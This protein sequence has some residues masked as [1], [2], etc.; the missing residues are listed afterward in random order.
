MNRF[1]LL[2]RIGSGGMGTVYRAFDERLQRHVAVK[3]I[4]LAGAERVMRE[5]QAAAR[6]NHPAIVTL[7]ELGERDGRA[8]L[9]SE[10]VDGCTLDELCEDGAISDRD[11]AMFGADVCEA[12]AHAHSR[13]VVH[14]DVKPQNVIVADLEGPSARAKL[15]DFGIASVAGSPTLTAPGA[16]LGTLSYMAP[17]QAEGEQCGPEAD[18]YAL[19]LTLYEAWAGENPVAGANA[20]QTARRIG[21]EQASLAAYRPDLPGTL[22]ANIDAC[23]EPHPMDRPELEELQGVLENAAPALDAETAVPH[24]AEAEHDAEGVP[25][26]SLSRIF[27]LVGTGVLAAALAGPAGLPGLALIAALL[28]IPAI[29]VVRNPASALL[30][31]LAIPAGAIGALLVVPVLIAIAVGSARERFVLGASA[32]AV[33]LSAAI[34]VGSGPRL[35]IA[36]PA[37]A[38]WEHSAGGAWSALGEPLLAP[39]ALLGI[40]ICALAAMVLGRLL[41]GSLAVALLGA[42]ALAAALETGLGA[43][44]D[45]GLGERPALALAAVGGALIFEW[46]LR[47]LSSAQRPRLASARPALDGGG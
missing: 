28:L 9:V 26:R 43:L 12:L 25:L 39:P 17:E 10:L 21:R 15:M 5:A 20:A 22:I 24:D 8:L 31:A 16:V 3:E 41:E 4:Q 44:G 27:A 38:G 13:G 18:V 7:Y 35:G 37:P 1:R 23:L 6:L 33:Y 11:V 14:R 32:F 19:G 36:G 34:A 2:E 40:A 42:A 29:F 45:G 47:D 30:P 46:R